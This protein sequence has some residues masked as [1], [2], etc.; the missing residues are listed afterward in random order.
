M[1]NVDKMITDLA[2]VIEN[3]RANG[4]RV[5]AKEMRLRAV[6]LVRAKARGLYASHM[7]NIV[8]DV[9]SQVA[10]ALAEMPLEEMS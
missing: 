7:A 6:Q 1:S 10:D 4:V 5:G 2:E 3:S 9:V 8:G